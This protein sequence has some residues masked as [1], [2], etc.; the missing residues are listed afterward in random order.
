MPQLI[1]GTHYIEWPGEPQAGEY[2]AR[3]AADALAHLIDIFTAATVLELPAPQ[4][5]ASLTVVRPLTNPYTV[6]HWA[7]TPATVLAELHLAATQL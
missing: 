3:S 4:A 1:S 5:S 6:G 2:V 7:G